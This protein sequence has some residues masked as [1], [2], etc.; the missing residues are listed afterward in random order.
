MGLQPISFNHSDTP[1]G[2]SAGDFRQA[3]SGG[4]RGPE[5]GGHQLV[6]ALDRLQW[7]EEDSQLGDPA[8]GV[9][10][11]VVDPLDLELAVDRGGEAQNDGAIAVD[12]VEV[13]EIF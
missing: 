3:R 7:A 8:V 9:E 5:G 6:E 4:R 11:E 1:P 12:L 10:V 2:G 13:G